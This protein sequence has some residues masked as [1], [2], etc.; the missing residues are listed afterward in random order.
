MNINAVADEV[1]TYLSIKHPRVYRNKAPQSPVFPYVVFMVESAVNSMPSEDLYVN[2][3]V[4]E[5]VN[6]SVRNMEDLADLI[7]NDLNH[8]VMNT[9]TLNLHFERESRQYVTP[10]E[11]VSAHLINLR[12]AVRAYFK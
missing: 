4:Y 3:D 12:Y 9:D 7:D 8:S 1:L 5:N 10:E 2:I 11:L 6:T